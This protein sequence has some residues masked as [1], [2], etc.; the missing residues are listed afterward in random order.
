[1]TRTILALSMVCT[2]CTVAEAQTPTQSRNQELFWSGVI[3][4]AIGGFYVGMDLG[5]DHSPSCI[6]T[7]IGRSVF[8]DCYQ[9]SH[10][11]LWY[12]L[13]LVGA[14]SAMEIASYKNIV[15]GPGYIGY[16]RRW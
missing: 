12:G 8:T 11:K 16:R 6:S 3:L 13:A 14:G 9:N 5:Q 15:A 4:S 2:L 1:M 7:T 10:N